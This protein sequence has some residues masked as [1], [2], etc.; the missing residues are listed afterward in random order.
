MDIIGRINRAKKIWE[1]IRELSAADI[2]NVLRLSADSYY[3][4]DESL[5]SDEDYD[6]LVDRLHKLNPKAQ[7][8]KGIGS[9][10]KGKKVRLPYWMGSMDKIKTEKEVDAW[11][12]EYAGPYVLSDKMDGVSCLLVFDDDEFTLYTRGNGT[13]GQNITHLFDIVNMF[14]TDADKAVKKIKKTYVD[15][16][17]AIR[18]ELIISKEKF[19]SKYAKTMKNGRNMVSGIVNT[20]PESLNKKHAADIDFIAY[21][22]IEPK[23]RPSE[24]F[25]L[26]E[27][28]GFNVAPHKLVES[29]DIEDLNKHLKKRKEKTAYEIDGIICADDAKHPRNTSGN[30]AYSFAYKGLSASAKTKVTDV[31][32]VAHKDGHIIPTI[33]YKK[34]TLSGADLR[35]TAGFNARFIKKNGI[36]PGAVIEVI[37]SGDTIPYLMDVIK[38]VKPSFPQL[39]YY[40]DKNKVNIILTNPEE[41][42]SVI[43]KRLTKFVVDI[44]V[45]NMSEGIITRLVAAGYDSIP[46]IMKLTAEDLYELDGFQHTLSDKLIRNLDQ[47]LRKLDILT[48][49]VASNC[50]G[51]GF[52]ERKI[53]KIL[54]VW[55]NIVAE[56]DVANRKKWAKKIL[57]LD[58]FDT[59]SMDGFLD[60]LPDFQAFYSIVRRIRPIKPY[61][62]PVKKAGG[63]FEGAVILFTGFREAAWKEIIES[64]G[65]RIASSFSGKTTLVVYV[66]GQESNAKYKDAVAAGTPTITKGAFKKKFNLP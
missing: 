43:I 40:W 9:P 10:I 51:K 52:G 45:E 30:P 18:G 35:K 2:E 24:Q 47:S 4:S 37:R 1:I 42:E 7:F 57:E 33:H 58:G 25:E 27:E 46:K 31:V 66:E 29:V 60:P 48:L 61:V 3:N 8:F 54:N 56:Y 62:P 36:G 44:G 65:G 16:I 19:E 55:P 53:R 11:T 38:P 41:N 49:M 34:V 20:K 39:D 13:E 32:W 6:V 17:F 59:I 23:K 22:L 64:E 15:S 63:R 50:F 14:D 5:I 26:L 21:E 12:D 28:L